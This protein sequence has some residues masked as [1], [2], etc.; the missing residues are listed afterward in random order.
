[1]KKP[2]LDAILYIRGISML[3]VIGIHIGS[4]YLSE[5]AAANLSLVV[6]FEI[7][8]RFA[9]PIFFFISAFGLFY[10]LDSNE[11]FSYKDFLKRRL[12]AVF[13]PYVVWSMIYTVH[14]AWFYGVG[15]PTFD[16][17]LRSLFFGFTKYH[18]YFLV[19]L[20]WFYLLMPLWIVVVKRLNLK[21]LA[22]L[23]MAQIIFDY[24]SSYDRT[25][26][27]YVYSLPES[28]YKDFFM[29]RLNFWVL[30]YFFIFLLGGYLSLNSNRFMA[31]LKNHYKTVGLFFVATT[32]AMIGGFYWC[33]VKLGYKGIDAVNTVHQLSPMGILYTVAAS[34]FF[35]WLFSYKPYPKIFNK[36]LDGLGSHSYFVYLAHPLAISWLTA[37]FFTKAQPVIAAQAIALY[38]A[39]LVFT[40]VV[41]V[42]CQKLY[43]KVPLLG[44]LLIGAR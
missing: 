43:K 36:I 5:N 1:M 4:V 30:H 42:V 27:I 10:N 21:W 32:A 38:L 24:W 34:L 39:V 7:L 25:F 11:E 12:N 28:F 23:L 37:I 44:K 19:I 14:D 9:V 18:L 2:R 20:I 15:M 22:F 16:Y 41:A 35:F 13:L 29:Y 17:F 40:L 8:T 33:V 26:N 6:C 3:G 31:E